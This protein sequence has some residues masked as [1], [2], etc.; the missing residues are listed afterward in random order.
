MK[1]LVVVFF[2]FLGACKSNISVIEEPEVLTTEQK[3]E[4]FIINNYLVESDWVC[5][6]STSK[7]VEFSYFNDMFITNEGKLY[8]SSIDKLFS[9]N[10]Q[11]C[12]I[13]ETD[14]KFKK[15]IHNFIISEGVTQ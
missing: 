14:V 8:Q 6:V 1:K 10:M 12:K 7:I 2:I 13:I 3:V 4:D 5:D 11:N 9:T 15:F